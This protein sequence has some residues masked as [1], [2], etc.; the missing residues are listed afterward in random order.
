[1]IKK[2]S[3][4][5]VL[6]RRTIYRSEYGY[7]GY[8]PRVVKLNKKEY[9]ASFIASTVLESPDSHPNICR[10]VDGGITWN[11]EGPVDKKRPEKFAPTET[12]FINKD[13]DGNLLCFG[14]RWDIDPENPDAPL[15]NPKTVGM[16]ENQIV[17]RRSFDGGHN[18]TEAQIIP[19]PID[20]PFELT[21]IVALPDDTHLMSFATW[22]KWDGSMP[23]GH[24]IMMMKSKDKLKTWGKPITIFYD[25]TNKVG[26]WEGRIAPIGENKLI[27][28]CWAHS[29]KTDEDLPNHFS[30]S[31]DNGDTWSNPK[32]T[33]VNGQTSSPMLL[34]EDI[35]LFVY[36]Y[37][38]KPSAVR[39]QIARIE[40]ENWKTIFDE[41]VWS[42]EDQSAK[43]ITKDNYAVTNFQFGLPSAIWIDEKNIM[44]VY[45]C[46]INK[47]AGI[48][49][50]V[51]T[52]K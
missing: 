40:N 29:W 48:D 32:E 52:L 11:M 14:S 30:I 12:G 25:L 46:V 37:R 21:G 16:R 45:W 49:C 39:A 44:V 47:R 2:F 13:A 8:Y 34:N 38:R 10:S 36:N 19:K 5:E 17:L 43:T 33:S 15:V 28:T 31:H 51:I 3:R 35:I 9:I 27:A 24:R 18:W 42:P 1:M 50:T 20:V 22:R 23:Y 41:K 4:I 26:F 6:E 7:Q